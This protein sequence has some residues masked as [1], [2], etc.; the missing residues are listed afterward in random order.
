[1][2]SISFNKFTLPNGLDVILHQDNSLPVVSVNVWYHVGSKDEE[3]G[4]TGYAH[5]FEHIMFEGSKHHNRSHFEPLQKVGANLNGST[6]TDRTNYW[7]DLPSNHL[8]LALW[9]EADRMGFL[10]DAMDQKSFDVQRDVV[11]NER[12]QSY[13]TQPYGMTT[14]PLQGSLYPAPHPNH[15]PTIG[16]HED[17]DIATLEDARSFFLRFYHPSNASIALAGDFQENMAID[18]VNK[19]FGDLNPGENISRFKQ[20]DSGLDGFVDNV[21]Y[22]KVLL[23]RLCLTRPSVPRFSP[24]EAPQSVLASILADGRSSRLYRSLVYKQRIAQSVNAF[25]SPS[26]IAGDF[27]VVAT[28]SE[29][30]NIQQI[31]ETIHAE[32]AQLQS[33]PPSPREMQRIK[34][35]IEMR[36]VRQMA[37]IGGFGGKANRLNF[38]N[39][40]KGDPDGINTDS[41][42]FMAV[43]SEDVSRVANQYFTNRHVRVTVLP[44]PSLKA[45]QSDV[46]RTIQPSAKPTPSFSPPTPQRDKLPNGL[47]LLLLEK[48][49]LPSIALGMVLRTGASMDP[50]DSPG[51]SS[52]TNAMVQEGTQKRTTSDISDEFEFIGSQLS[53]M[54]GRERTLFATETLSKHSDAALELMSDVILNPTF[55]QQEVDRLST[56][57][58]TSLKRVKDDANSLAARTAPALLY[59]H[60]SP[61]GHPI[62]GDEYTIQNITRDKLS[63]HYLKTFDPAIATLIAVGD[64]SIGD[65]KSQAQKYF[66]T[67]P[68]SKEKHTPPEQPSNSLMLDSNTIYLL[69]KPGAAQSVIRAGHIGVAAHHPDYLALSVLNHI[70]GGQ[71]TARLNMNLRQDKGYSYGYRSWIEWHEQSSLILTGGGVQTNV[72]RESVEENIKEFNGMAGDLEIT[73][74]EFI[75]SKEALIRQFPAAFETNG[76]VLDHLA[77]LV[78]F[79]LPDDYYNTYTERLDSITLDQVQTAARK[80]LKKDSL[81]ILVVGD[82]TQIEPELRKLNLPIFFVNPQVEFV[83]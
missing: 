78:Y 61:Y 79:D 13:E 28:A 17:L 83:D 72:T 9:L 24:D 60:D 39:V 75:A 51:L 30:Q 18:L 16:F 81:M 1:M 43:R 65:L 8:E 50:V 47:N 53:G 26:E 7:E 66:G 68:T 5:L 35:K 67:W 25:H 58:T 70:F 41:E 76:Q 19:Y 29:G 33:T 74:E 6:T 31:E 55:P 54:T 56:D 10:L 14:L 49:G 27:E 62:T 21:T 12:R 34:N 80:H 63:E 22:D 23:P 82:R 32:I 36:Q 11:K 71:F 40:F 45:S 46:D 2:K 37:S 64:I 15:W 3:P 20:T 48:R 52:F 73:E 4:K 57:R 69:N 77:Q 42:R 44:E 59:G 38:F